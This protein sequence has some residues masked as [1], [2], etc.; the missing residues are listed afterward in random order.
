MLHA[1]ASPI[2]DTDAYNDFALVL[3]SMLEHRRPALRTGYR[4]YS[5]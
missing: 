2:Y 4:G 1:I 3:Q 5:R